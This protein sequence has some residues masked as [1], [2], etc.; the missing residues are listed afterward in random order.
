MLINDRKAMKLEVRRILTSPTSGFRMR[1]YL[2]F[3]AL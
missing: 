2:A 3:V 1:F